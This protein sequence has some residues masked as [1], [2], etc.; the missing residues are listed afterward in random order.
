MQF[1]CLLGATKRHSCIGN[2]LLEPWME[3]A[4]MR[5]TS[6][7]QGWAG[8]VLG[9]VAFCTVVGVGGRSWSSTHWIRSVPKRGRWWWPRRKRA[10]FN[11]QLLQRHPRIW[12]LR[13]DVWVFSPPT[14]QPLDSSSGPL[15]SDMLIP[16]SHHPKR[17]RICGRAW[18]CGPPRNQ[19]A[20]NSYRSWIRE[21]ASV[22]ST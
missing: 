6:R 9:S 14:A 2:D 7:N 19:L 1:Q 4:W 3:S 5:L 8:R 16:Q 20:E 12:V 11:Q 22:N 13:D 10:L 17:L 21:K 15:S 18:K